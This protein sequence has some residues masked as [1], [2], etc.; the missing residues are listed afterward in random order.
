VKELGVGVEGLLVWRRN[1]VENEKE[2]VWRVKRV[3]RVRDEVEVV[4]SSF[5]F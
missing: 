3:C 1:W 4:V 2:A 5:F